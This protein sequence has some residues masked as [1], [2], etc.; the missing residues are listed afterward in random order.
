MLLNIQSQDT[1][2]D[3]QIEQIPSNQSLYIYEKLGLIYLSS[4]GFYLL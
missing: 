3:L 4:F 2:V 1:L